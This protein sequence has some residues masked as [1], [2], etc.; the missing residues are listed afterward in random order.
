MLLVTT[1]HADDYSPLALA[2]L[3]SAAQ[4]VRRGTAAEVA[5]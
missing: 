4:S 1:L 2:F 5:R 3:A